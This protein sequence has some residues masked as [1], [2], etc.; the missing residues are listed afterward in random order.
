MELNRFVYIYLP[1]WRPTRGIVYC[2]WTE[3]KGRE[4]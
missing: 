1:L 3:N 4:R 2:R